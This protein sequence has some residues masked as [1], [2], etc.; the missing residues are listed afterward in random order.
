MPSFRQIPSDMHVGRKK[1]SP[2]FSPTWW[3]PNIKTKACSCTTFISLIL[4]RGKQKKLLIFF[5][6]KN[7]LEILSMSDGIFFDNFF[8]IAGNLHFIRF[9]SNLWI[10]WL[11]KWLFIINVQM[12]YLCRNLGLHRALSF[13]ER[14]S[15]RHACKFT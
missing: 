5:Y 9:D 10:K 1:C 13:H 2:L 8:K 15:V 3:R 11:M 6:R 14:N 4:D 12:S 7:F